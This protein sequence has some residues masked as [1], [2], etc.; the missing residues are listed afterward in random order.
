VSQHTDT[1]GRRTAFS[2][3]PAATQQRANGLTSGSDEHPGN[4][5]RIIGKVRSTAGSTAPAQTGVAR[6]PCAISAGFLAS[7]LPILKPRIPS[8]PP[9]RHAALQPKQPPPHTNRHQPG[10]DVGSQPQGDQIGPGAARHPTTRQNAAADADK[11]TRTLRVP[12]EHEPAAP[13][14]AVS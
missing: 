5:M 10:S 6:R 12:I 3:P 9:T 14:L 11:A 7:Q 13:T 8:I 1:K 2:Q 4:C